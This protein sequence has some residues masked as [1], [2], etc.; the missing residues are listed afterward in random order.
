MKTAW[1]WAW[2]SFGIIQAATADCGASGAGAC[3]DERQERSETLIERAERWIERN[4]GESASLRASLPE[5]KVFAWAVGLGVACWIGRLTLRCRRRRAAA[6][7]I[8]I[9]E[10]GRDLVRSRK[11]QKRG[12]FVR[13]TRTVKFTLD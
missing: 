3:F 7:E 8:R 2:L 6:R 1:I 12:R 5:S 9:R 10:S 4:Q 11:R 13:R